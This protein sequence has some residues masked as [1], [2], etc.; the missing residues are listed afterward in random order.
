M[1]VSVVGGRSAWILQAS[2]S[3]VT[4]GTGLLALFSVEPSSSM[5]LGLP[6]V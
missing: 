1:L 5:Q 6:I 2:W 4:L 3:M